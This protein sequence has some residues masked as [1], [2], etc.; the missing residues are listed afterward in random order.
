MKT[1]ARTVSGLLWTVALID[2][3]PKMQADST[4]T[5]L[6]AGIDLAR[7]QLCKLRQQHP[8][9]TGML[10]MPDAKLTCYFAWFAPRILVCRAGLRTTSNIAGRGGRVAGRSAPMCALASFWT[11]ARHRLVNIRN[12]ML[13]YRRGVP[14]GVTR[15]RTPRTVAAK[16]T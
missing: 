5:Y 7:Q 12:F 10:V 15:P 11:N 9:R 13:P 2:R 6:A 16:G 3:L 8:D 14:V 1:I 4:A